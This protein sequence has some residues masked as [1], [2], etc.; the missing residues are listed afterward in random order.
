MYDAG[1]QYGQMNQMFEFIAGMVSDY[2][3]WCQLHQA[4]YVDGKV[5]GKNNSLQLIIEN[6]IKLNL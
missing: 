5:S 3:C 4:E 6:C 2:G 1:V